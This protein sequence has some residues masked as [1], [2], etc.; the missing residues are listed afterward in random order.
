MT[1]GVG[2]VIVTRD[3]LGSLRRTLQHTCSLPERPAI[4]VVDNGS[5]DGTDAAVRREHPDLRVVRLERDA[6]GAARTVGV[7]VLATDAVAFSDDDSWWEPGSLARSA[8]LFDANPSLGLIAARVLVGPG[9][10]LDPTCVQMAHSPLAPRPDLPG[11]PVLGFLACGAIVRRSA[12]LEVGGFEP[13]FGIGGEEQLLALDLVAAEW[14]LA[15]VEE[16]VA[17]HHPVRGAAG[18]ERRRATELRNRIW[19]AWLRRPVRTAVSL[20]ASTALR[21]LRER[22]ADAVLEALRG[23]RWVLRER[24]VLPVD[25]ERDARR[26]WGR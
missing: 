11:P 15:Y 7:R 3:R 12:Y 14:D 25:V 20:S 17:H 23:L 16:I 6:G 18:R 21:S 19:A 13:R 4:V 1:E 22:R 8:R 5:H 9:R 26:L 2:V 24:R 10:D